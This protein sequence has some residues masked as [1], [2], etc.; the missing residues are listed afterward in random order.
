MTFLKNCVQLIEKGQ[1]CYFVMFI[2]QDYQI[3]N[4]VKDIKTYG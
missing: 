3:G 2:S 1:T 4:G